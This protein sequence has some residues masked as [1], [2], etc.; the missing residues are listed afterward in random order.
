MLLHVQHN[1]QIARR[2][3]ERPSFAAASKPDPR[4]VFHAGRNFRVHR[5]LP[6][7]PSLAFALRAWVCNH[8]AR[9]LTRRTSARNTEEALLIPHLP[10]TVAGTASGRTFARR[11]ARAMAIFTGFVTTYQ[12]ARL[13]AECSL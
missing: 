1:V 7:N 3:A 4:A 13:G 11:R 12:H 9:P 10:A 8:V 2:P 5:A 6:Q